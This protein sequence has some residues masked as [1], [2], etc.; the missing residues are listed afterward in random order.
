[1]PSSEATT[2]CI[3]RALLDLIEKKSN[4]DQKIFSGGQL[5]KA[6]GIPRSVISRLIHPDP[7]KR[8]INPTVGTLIKIVDF[9]R[10]DGFNV[11]LDSFL[12]PYSNIV[13][14]QTQAIDQ[15]NELIQNITLY[16]L[17]FGTDTPIGTVDLKLYS[18]SPDLIAFLSEKYIKPMFKKGS[19]FVVDKRMKVENGMLIAIK[20]NN[21]PEILV[22]KYYEID[23]QKIL[24]S[25]DKST[26]EIKSET[27]YK[28]IGVII[29]VNAKT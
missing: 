3:Q 14:V 5:A 18:K 22:K 21:S 27:P 19:I 25:Y 17:T 16:T 11:S 13:N 4:R 29:H 15:T 2:Y 24:K 8:V 26:L 23:D 9:F 10:A 7:K 20:Q 6:L 28:I 12:D 1:M